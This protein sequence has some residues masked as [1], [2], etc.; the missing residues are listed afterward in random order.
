MRLFGLLATAALLAVGVAA[1]LT[2]IPDSETPD[3]A[4][5]E[6]APAAPANKATHKKKHKPAKPKL[7]PAQRR[8][9]A[10]AVTILRGQG[11]RPVTLKDYDPDH[12]LRVLIGKGDG[13]RRAFFFAGGTYLGNDAIDDS[14]FVKVVHTGNRSVALSYKLFKPGDRACCPRGGSARV[15]FR[16]DGQILAAQTPVP[17]AA[18]R[19]APA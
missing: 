9:R 12:V 13:G 1:A 10:A 15:L 18:A 11:Y 19:H 3:V 6:S 8:A 14:G 2:V 4:L 16:W 5:P 17:A 7:T